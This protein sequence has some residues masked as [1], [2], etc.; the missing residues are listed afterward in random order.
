MRVGQKEARTYQ[1]GREQAMKNCLNS[2]DVDAKCRRY[3]SE[4]SAIALDIS[5]LCK[6]RPPFDP[7]DHFRIACL[8][9]PPDMRDRNI[10]QGI[11]ELEEFMATCPRR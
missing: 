10:D 5:R 7:G 9:W 6:T 8:S 4:S 11:A 2:K 1:R 3:A